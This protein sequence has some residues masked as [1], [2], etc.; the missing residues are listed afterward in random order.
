MYVECTM[1]TSEAVQVSSKWTRSA[2]LCRGNPGPM[3]NH[4][5]FHTVQ[6]FD[7][8]FHAAFPLVNIQLMRVDTE[9]HFI[10]V[11]FQF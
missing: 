10:L 3:S 9:K 7:L 1:H 6:Y 2:P 5:S 11:L 8:S 4:D